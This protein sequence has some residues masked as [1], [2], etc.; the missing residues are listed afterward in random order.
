MTAG[1]ES[2]RE[3]LQRLLSASRPTV[4]KRPPIVQTKV[5][6]RGP[7]RSDHMKGAGMSSDE[8]WKKGAKP[9]RTEP[10]M[11][12][13]LGQGA[14]RG[15]D[16]NTIQITVRKKHKIAKTVQVSRNVRRDPQRAS[17]KQPVGRAGSSTRAG[18][19]LSERRGPPTPR[20]DADRQSWKVRGKALRVAPGVVTVS[21]PP[22]GREPD[23]RWAMAK[24][25]DNHAPRQTVTAASVSGPKTANRSR[26]QSPAR[27]QT[28]PASPVQ[29][30]QRP[31][32]ELS[33]D[34]HFRMPDDWVE[35]GRLLQVSTGAQRDLPIRLGV[36]FGTAYT[37]LAV[38]LAGKVFLIDWEGIHAGPRPYLLG[39]ELSEMLH[40]DV[41]VGR[42][43]N[44]TQVATNLKL[45][46]LEFDQQAGQLELERAAIFLAWILRYA[47]AWL[48]RNQASVLE[49]H[50]LIWE[51]N[52]GA[53]TG[54]WTRGGELLARYQRVALTA[55]RLSQAV[56]LTLEQASQVMKDTTAAGAGWGLDALAILPE[57][58]AQIAAYVN[59]PQRSD[60]LY[61]LADVGAGTLDVAC[62]RI[63]KVPGAHQNR[64]PV[65]ASEVEPLGTHYM[66]QHRE[67]AFG[68]LGAKWE[69]TLEVPNQPEFAQLSGVSLADVRNADAGFQQLV[70]AVIQR[71]LTWTR[72]RM[73]RTAPEWATS[74]PLFFAG[75]GANLD[76]Y[77]NGVDRA[78]ARSPWK[79]KQRR[80]PRP[81]DL[82]PTQFKVDDDVIARMSV[83][84]GLTFDAE[85]I[86]QFIPPSD[87]PLD[88]V[89]LSR[90]RPDRDD[91]YPK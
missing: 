77:R 34:T 63:M 24:H 20:T 90:E 71:V 28:E 56:S 16:Q 29:T 91:M 78:F 68:G 9:L 39:G 27:L 89:P 79:Y 44:A 38:R 7:P 49:G 17:G 82:A 65:F 45:P 67:L 61:L 14:N 73:D 4:S 59:S 18:G 47:R 58:A 10:R 1:G 55:W 23:S 81:R 72:F 40:D 43:P 11:L 25:G 52:L 83:A 57:F 80:F 12:L 31:A 85:Q 13:H 54:S 76:V 88:F 51:L 32:P 64:F 42:A 21:R 86:G 41:L 26:A 60:G 74:I 3:Q 69:S 37:K 87:I 33:N 53:P 22:I 70:G 35:G 5:P 84:Y 30:K 75:G 62:F 66:M 6:Q 15:H 50:R 8:E 19:A 36:D 46:F 48:Y 2:I